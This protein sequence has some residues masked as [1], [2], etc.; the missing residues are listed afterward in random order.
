MRINKNIYKWRKTTNIGD[1]LAALFMSSF[2]L[3]GGLG[4]NNDYTT[5]NVPLPREAWHLLP[6][7]EKQEKP[8]KTKNLEDLLAAPLLC[9]FWLSGLLGPN[10]DYTAISVPLPR[11]TR[12]LFLQDEKQENMKKEKTLERN[13]QN[14][15]C[16]VF[17]FLAGLVP[18]T[19]APR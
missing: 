7:N 16:L 15:C 5:I 2:R 11:E 1:K 18:T 10:S 17:D 6:Q 19:T 4:P 12:Q 9:T 3:A 14:I 8:R 13:S